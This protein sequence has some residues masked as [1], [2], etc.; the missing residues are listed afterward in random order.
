MRGPDSGSFIAGKSV[1]NQRI[2]R[3]WRDVWMGVTNVFYHIL[4]ML[5]EEGLLDLGNA[6][7]FF[8]LHYVF[9]P[10]LQENLNLFRDGWDNHPLRTERN[11]TP[12]QL[13]EGSDSK[14]EQFRRYLDK[15][16]VLDGLTNVLVAL[17]EET[18]KP[19]N[20]LDFIKSHL[21]GVGVEVSDTEALRLELTEL[22]QKYNT[23]M[24]ENKDLKKRLCH[25]EAANEDGGAE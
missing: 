15:T 8:C 6:T 4:H 23:L 16:G 17:Y 1:H 3:L 14:R 22:Q 7:H 2:E 20:A 25:Y 11:L 13:W 24:E 9:L 12:N 19:N 18:E 10:R 5:E 21:S